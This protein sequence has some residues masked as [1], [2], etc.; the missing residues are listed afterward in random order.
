[1]FAVLTLAET[2][3]KAAMCPVAGRVMLTDRFGI[4]SMLVADV[5]S[6]LA[7]SQLNG[8][9]VAATL[10]LLDELLLRLL[11]LDVELLLALDSDDGLDVLLL[12]RLEA[13]DWLDVLLL[14]KLLTLDVLLDESVLSDPPALID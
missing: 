9:C 3:I 8:I 1:L 10:L 11:R 13:D 4:F 2:A 12:D 5:V 6:P 7:E 14:L